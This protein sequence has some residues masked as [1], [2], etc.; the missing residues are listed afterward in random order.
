MNGLLSL[1]IL[2]PTAG[3]LAILFLP[4][5][6]TGPIKALAT[7]VAGLTFVLSLP[8]WFAKG[9]RDSAGFLIECIAEMEV[10]LDEAAPTRVVEPGENLSNWKVVNQW[11]HLPPMDWVQHHNRMVEAETCAA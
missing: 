8:L 6:K 4:R 11:G 2:L 10:I 7:A 9:F 3:A 1:L 5:E